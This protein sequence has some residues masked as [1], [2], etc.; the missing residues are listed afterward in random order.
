VGQ[1]AVLREGNDDFMTRYTCYESAGIEVETPTMSM[2]QVLM[3]HLPIDVILIDLASARNVGGTNVFG[4]IRRA[5]E[6]AQVSS[7]AISAVQTGLGNRELVTL[8][9]A[10]DRP[11]HQT[12]A[13]Q[14]IMTVRNKRG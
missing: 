7:V 3:F 13:A 12:Q 9:P 14:Q 8:A 5:P 4:G 1:T 2:P 10:I 6:L 11:S